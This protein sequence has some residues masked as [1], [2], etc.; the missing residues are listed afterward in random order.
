MKNRILPVLLVI[1]AFTLSLNAKVVNLQDARQAAKNAFFERSFHFQPIDFSEINISKTWIEK[2]NNE[3][4]FYIF[5]FE[6]GGF[7]IISGEDVLPPVLG[8]DPQGTC[9]NIGLDPNFDSFMKSYSEQV[10][11]VRNNGLTAEA[12]VAAEWKK[13]STSDPA[14]LSVQTDDRGVLPLLTCLWNQNYPYNKLSPE[15][16]AGPGGH[17]YAGCVATAM[18]MVMYYWRYPLQGTGSHT[19]YWDPYGSISANFGATQYNWEQMKDVM[20]PNYDDVALIQFHCGVG[21]DMMYSPNGSGAYSHDVPDAIQDYFGYSSQSDF[22]Q[23]DD[24]SQQN[25][26][27]LL[28]QQ[29]DL[30]QPMYYS[31]YSNSGG[32][33]FVC[34]GYDDEDNFHFNF[35]WSG[36]SNG[37]YTL[38]TVG[39]FS[40]GQGA[41][42]N[43]IPGGN[44]PYYY[45]GQQPT[46]TA[47]SGSFEDGS[48]PV[49][50]Y[51]AGADISWLIDPQAAGDSVSK[52]TLSFSRFSL[53]GGDEITVYGGESASAPVLAVFSGTTIPP[54]FVYNGNKMFINFKSNTPETA[55]G[56]LASYTT[57]KPTWCNGLTTFTDLSGTVTDGSG[58]FNYDNNASCMWTIEPEGNGPTTLH[59]SA[60]DTEAQHDYLIIYDMVSQEMLA[61][62]SGSYSADN[63]PSPIVSNSGKFFM[64]FMTN[65]TVNLQ[66]WEINYISE[67]VGIDDSKSVSP[68]VE[69][70][71]N[72]A[73]DM[74]NLQLTG[75]ETGEILTE[76]YALDGRLAKT[77]SYTIE[78]NKK[79]VVVDVNELLSGSYLLKV[80]QGNVFITRKINIR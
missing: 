23:K 52:I 42:I 76:I 3:P 35:G 22:K 27:G 40:N 75:F 8:Y 45:S 15:D 68:G 30:G 18:S 11:F 1:L 74:L 62:I 49:E 14:T 21:V 54:A 32:H 5:N 2:L 38:Y 13:Y 60:F 51:P 80:S 63:L 46:L 47:K 36:S 24:Y 26:I 44:Y 71:P 4:A 59:F 43:F 19:Y 73:I 48:G 9:S 64:I 33:A 16:P 41:V 29:I 12:T 28:K 58:Q 34:D 77:A 69:I 79:G 39:G 78:K 37:Y 56:F 66:G 10:A 17:V 7:V 70:F 61:Q 20:D 31:G 65:G 72:P 53:A 6:N 67:T 57:S 55:N 25:W 50:H